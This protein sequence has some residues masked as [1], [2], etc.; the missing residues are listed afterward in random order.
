MTMNAENLALEIAALQ[1]RINK[2]SA[3]LAAK[4]VELVKLVGNEGQTFT[5][6]LGKVQVTKQTVDRAT[7]QFSFALSVE[8]FLAQDERIQANLIRD[9]VVVRNEKITRGTAPVVKVS[10]A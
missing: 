3:D 8:A 6:A 1:Q 5:T 7:G 4:K 2:D 10:F 9:G